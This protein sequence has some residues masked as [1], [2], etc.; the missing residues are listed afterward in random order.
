MAREKFIWCRNCDAIHR[1]SGFDKAPVYALVAGEATEQPAD[2]WRDFMMQHDG[3]RLE[4]LRPISEKYFPSG[5][6]GDPMSVGY[7][8]VTNG[9][10][11]L[12]LRQSRTAIDAPVH[13]ELIAGRLMNR[14]VSLAVQGKEIKKEMTRHFQWP[15]GNPPSDEKIDLFIRLYKNVIAAL[16]PAQVEVVGYSYVDDNIAYGLADSVTIEKLIA[17]CAENFNPDE[18]Q[19]ICAFIKNHRGACDVMS[20]VMRRQVAIEPIISS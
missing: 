18:F 5:S 17:L 1:V 19:G 20:L 2:D 3:H 15:G 4:P 11:R 9:Q 6:I 8:E 14:G 7:V 13:F 12:L 16:N 10:D